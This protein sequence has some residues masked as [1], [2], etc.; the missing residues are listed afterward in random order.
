MLVDH[1]EGVGNRSVGKLERSAEAAQRLDAAIVVV[2]PPFRWRDYARGFV[3][4]SV[5]STR[6]PGVTFC[7]ENMYPY[8]APR[9]ES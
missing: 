9:T 7:V 4:E 1:P 3:E 2:H 5:G 6:T 8:G